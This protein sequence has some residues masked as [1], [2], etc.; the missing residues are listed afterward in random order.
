MCAEDKI[1]LKGLA[2]Y[3]SKKQRGKQLIRNYTCS[4]TITFVHVVTDIHYPGRYM[5]YNRSVETVYVYYC[6]LGS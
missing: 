1:K 2:A 4:S 6:T 5:I 3:A